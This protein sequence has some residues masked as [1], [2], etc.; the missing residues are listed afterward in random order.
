MK[1]LRTAFLLMLAL[2][3]P[4]A[5][6][7]P[8]P[9][10]S[11]QPYG[12]LELFVGVRTATV[13]LT[14]GTAVSTAHVV[15]V[16][17]RAPG[18]SFLASQSASG[19]P[20][21]FNQ[22]LTTDFL[23]RTHSQVAFNGNL[24]T[25]CCCRYVPPDAAVQTNLIG[26]E[27]SDGRILSPVE[28]KPPPLKPNACGETPAAAFPFDYSL[29]VTDQGVLIERPH[30][31]ATFISRAYAA[32]T[33]SHLLVSGGRNVAPTD[34]TGEFFGPNARTLVGLTADDTVL[35]IAA[36]DRSTS[37]GV[38]LPQAG[39]L[40]ILLGAA[41]AL[42]LDGG[43]STSLAVEDEGGNARL[44][45]LPNDTASPCT[46]PVGTHCARYVGANFGIRALRSL[47]R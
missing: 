9:S 44:L 10:C 17:L 4:A 15:R 28:A 25:N 24:F 45:N 31:V 39:Q 19:G 3:A 14:C 16:D 32:V 8:E 26:L 29:L 21:P 30:A 38:T 2:V 46:L 1:T 42:N 18:L 43:G 37:Q 40:M 41:T 33:G 35:W 5:A 47:P 36:V 27:I 13:A 7:S 22:E 11:A 34:G 12:V 6:Q 23:K 20:G